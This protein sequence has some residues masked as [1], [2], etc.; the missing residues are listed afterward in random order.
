MKKMMFVV[1]GLAL[2]LAFF[3]PANVNAVT[4]KT[5]VKDYDYQYLWQ[6]E[7]MVIEQG[8]QS[9]FGVEL[10]NTGTKAWDSNGKNPV[11]LG[12]GS[13]YGNSNQQYDYINEFDKNIEFGTWL[14]DNRVAMSP[15]TNT[16][17]NPGDWTQFAIYFHVP[18]DM[19]PGVYKMYFTPVADGAYWMKDVGI[20]FQVTVIPKSSV[21]K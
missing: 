21:S 11:R 13:V 2:G 10:K 9:S 6:N 4:K 15:W 12:S 8:Q 17:V 16:Y 18:D 19:K 3:V 5:A 7:N 14:S 20:Y 1:A